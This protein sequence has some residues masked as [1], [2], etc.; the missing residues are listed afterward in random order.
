[1]IA[2]VRLLF[3][4]V[5]LSVVAAA[6]GNHANDGLRLTGSLIVNGPGMNGNIQAN[7]K[8][9]YA[10]TGI[11][12]GNNYTVRTVIAPG[13]TLTGDIYQT[14]EDYLSSSPTLST[15]PLV[16]NSTATCIHEVYF[17][18]QSSG[19]H[20]LAL[21]GVPGPDV[22]SLYV[23]DLRLLSSSVTTTLATAPTST[24]YAGNTASIVA[25]YLHIY[26]GATVSPPGTYT[27]SLTSKSTSTLGNPQMF[28]YAGPS[29]TADSLLYSSISTS[30][31]YTIHTIVSGGTTS[32]SSPVNAIPNV[33]FSASGPFIL[34][35]GN[36]SV[37]YTLTI[38]P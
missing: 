31:D 9:V 14:R 36:A 1:M 32:V 4:A 35:K 15:Y 30:M 6:C 29:L 12:Q 11:V 8:R 37:D 33:S 19:D 22:N 2:V 10:L 7:T 20:Y 13:G 26:S 21:G 38:G 34:L 18:A 3:L 27:V 24:V 28:I 17:T 23:Y 5:I 16:S 25:E